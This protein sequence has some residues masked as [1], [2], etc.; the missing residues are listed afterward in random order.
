[1]LKVIT[2]E[3]RQTNNVL[4]QAMTINEMARQH[5]FG[6]VAAKLTISPPQVVLLP[7]SG[8]RTW[9]H[10]GVNGSVLQVAIIRSSNRTWRVTTE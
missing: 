10:L 9:Q 4:D 6:Q 8:E 5:G 3:L 1:M 2:N 7:Q